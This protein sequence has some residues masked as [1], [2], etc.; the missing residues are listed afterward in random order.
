[1]GRKGTAGA[2]FFS[3][4]P[5]YPIDTAYFS[6]PTHLDG[7]WFT[8]LLNYLDL[9]KLDQST[10]I[11]S[12]SRERYNPIVVPVPGH[13]QQHQVSE[14]IDE[15]FSQIEAGEQAL[16]GAQKLLERYRQSV[17]NAAVSGELTRDW[18]EQHRGEF[19]SGEALLKRVLQARREAWERAELA[20]MRAR[21]KRPS[22]DRWK[23]K[24]SEPEPPD[25]S[26]LPALPEGWVWA[27]LPML[28]EFGRGKSKHRPRNDPALYGGKYPFI[29]TG[30]VRHSGGRITK[31]TQTYNEHGL[32]QSKLWPEGTI[33]I[34][35]AANIAE[36][37]ILQFEACF[38]D[39]VVGLVPIDFVS[40]D[41]VELF[42]RT[43]KGDIELY[44]PATAQKNI[45]LDILS[46]VVIPMPPLGEQERIADIVGT[47]L[48]A[49]DVAVQGLRD[50]VARSSNLRQCMLS[51]A[52]SG[53]LVPQD[54][55]DEPA[56]V[57]LERIR[58]E[59]AASTRE[60]GRKRAGRRGR[61]SK[62][63]ELAMVK[64][65]KPTHLRDLIRAS[66]GG[67]AAEA[68]W[69]ASELDIDDFYKQLRN[70]V[71]AGH[72]REER[73]GTIS[74]IVCR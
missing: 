33:C 13:S 37:G 48:S 46:K 64:R 59:R 61:R 60:A 39:S 28:G 34:T 3:P 1:M 5:C 57:L 42:L 21:G 32:S 22:D 27:T 67:M 20:K 63:G 52:F 69:M 68:L 25:T 18:R 36:T 40:G 14:R 8:H 65:K 2:A 31:Y 50:G 66:N 73:D 49:A 55:T 26:V 10:T 44:A 15:L 12:L 7:R 4:G 23:Q 43:A 51:A 53:K 71:A 41:Y 30:D 70:E 29:Q 45:N 9:G 35:I 11:P 17:L 19:E 47:A 56:S 54:S 74:R 6:E 16:E 58:E 24:Y 62:K 38:P 72:L